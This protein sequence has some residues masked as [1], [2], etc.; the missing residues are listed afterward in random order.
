MLFCFDCVCEMFII[1]VMCVKLKKVFEIKD[2]D[3]SELI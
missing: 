1:S 3:D 2:R